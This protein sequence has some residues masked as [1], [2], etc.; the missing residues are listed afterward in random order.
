MNKIILVALLINLL[1]IVV[2]AQQIQD[3]ELVSPTD[4]MVTEFFNIASLK[5]EKCPDS[6]SSKENSKKIHV[7]F[8]FS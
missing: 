6:S 3:F 1:I 2:T 8:I 7:L 4:C 5:C